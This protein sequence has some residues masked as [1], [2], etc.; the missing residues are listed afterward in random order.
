MRRLA[1]LGLILPVLLV[2]G[3]STSANPGAAGGIFGTVRAGPICP[4]EQA[5]SPCPPQP[6]SGSVRA[7][8]TDGTTFTTTTDGSGNY[9]LTV[10]A[11]AYTVVAVTDEDTL[12]TGI[13][14]DVVVGGDARVRV[15]L[16]VD[17]GIR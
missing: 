3:C 11:G 16:E 14:S 10:P 12:P 5:G 13:P 15:D 6:W 7:T 2:V 9:A 17:T 4:V 8:A 1:G